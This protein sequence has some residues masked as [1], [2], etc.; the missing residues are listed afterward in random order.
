MR[1][2]PAPTD[3]SCAV[4]NTAANSKIA[5]LIVVLLRIAILG[6]A[7]K[8]SPEKSRPC[9]FPEDLTIHA[10]VQELSE[11]P[12]YLCDLSSLTVSILRLIIQP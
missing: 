5:T 11:L 7:K 2:N 8:K 1:S 4:Q 10:Q 12:D 9:P 3:D 6:V